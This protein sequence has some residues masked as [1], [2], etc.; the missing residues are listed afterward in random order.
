MGTES[1]FS[2]SWINEHE[3]RL[4]HCEYIPSGFTGEW[5][6]LIPESIINSC[7]GLDPVKKIHKKIWTTTIYGVSDGLQRSHPEDL[8]PDKSSAGESSILKNS[9][10]PCFFFSLRTQAAFRGSAQTMSDYMGK[11]KFALR[12]SGMPGYVC[13]IHQHVSKLKNS[14]AK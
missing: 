4:F 6:I 11:W 2:L 9:P 8:P 10:S 14:K 3:G 13:L 1:V 7:P 5:W 12:N